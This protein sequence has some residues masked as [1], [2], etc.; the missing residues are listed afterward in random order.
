MV[1]SIVQ[2]VKEITQVKIFEKDAQG[3][4]LSGTFVGRPFF[5]DY[6]KLGLLVCDS[7]KQKAGGL[8]QGC[9]LLAFYKNEEQVSEALLLRVLQPTR[10]PSDSHIISSMIEYYKD[11]L[12]TTGPNS[13]LDSFTRY[14]FSFSGVECRILGTFYHDENNKLQFGADVENFYSAHNYEVYKPTPEVLEFMVNYS[15]Q[16]SP[17]AFVIG[18]V[19]YSSS[20]RFQS[21]NKK[22]VPV[23]VLPEDFLGK[24]TAL[25]GMTRTGKSNT[26]KKIIQATCLMSDKAKNKSLSDAVEQV[27]ILEP[28]KDGVP[29]FPVGQLIFDINGEYAN[30]NL[31]DQGTA[32]FDIYKHK[33]ERYSIVDKT[34]LGFK[35]MKVNFYKDIDAGFKLIKA[36]LSNSEGTYIKSFCT[37]D[38][39]M[40]NNYYLPTKDKTSDEKHASIAYDKKVAIYKCILH[41]AQFKVPSNMSKIKFYGDAKTINTIVPHMKPHD[42][43]TLD[44]AQEW[45]STVFDAMGNDEHKALFEDYKKEKDGRPFFDE[46]MLSLLTMLTRKSSPGKL[47]TLSGYRL[48]R[49]FQHL[50]SHLSDESFEIDILSSL[51]SGNIVIIDLSQGDEKTQSIY[52][53]KI[54]EKIFSDSMDRFTQSQPN[55]FI[56]FYFEEAHNLFPKKDDKDLSQIYNRLAKEGAKL[57]LGMIYATQEVSSISSNILKNTQNWFIAH[58][59]NMDETKELQKYYDFSDFTESLVKFSSTNDK[60]FVRMKTYSSSYVVPTQIGLFPDDGS[61]I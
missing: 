53:E 56:Q 37:S 38:L 8:P 20:K 12:E 48:F 58:L 39:V 13:K 49:E 25:F 5:V 41:A 26:V 43:L 23:K 22:E 21:Q 18:N 19:R 27:E 47:P 60:G 42:G 2:K 32:I 11:N 59:N 52:S 46:D 34:D 33:T 57:H 61:K 10:L 6:Q 30:P 28:I 7:W 45:F 31:Q 29:L 51:R 24:R 16:Q 44:Q 40:P 4:F 35:V 50:H 1:V 14:E 36:G 55:N 15:E 9:F 3:K 17:H 54:T